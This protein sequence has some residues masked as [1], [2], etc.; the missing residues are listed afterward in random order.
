MH[1]DTDV[2]NQWLTPS[3]IKAENDK[4]EARRWARRSLINEWRGLYHDIKKRAYL[5]LALI[6][7]AVAI[8]GAIVMVAT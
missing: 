7:I 5:R 2:L 6:S 8:V 4:A 1:Q 3:Q